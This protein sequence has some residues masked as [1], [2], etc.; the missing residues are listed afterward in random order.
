M[1]S[2]IEQTLCGGF[3]TRSWNT[4][5][6]SAASAPVAKLGTMTPAMP[7]ATTRRVIS[8]DDGW[9]P[10][11]AGGEKPPRADGTTG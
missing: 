3:S 10:R 8:R 9:I 7:I 1:R 11:V 6:T 5:F 4:A 2:S